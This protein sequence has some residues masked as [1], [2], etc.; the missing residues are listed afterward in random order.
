[1]NFER[2]T[3]K[4]NKK[5]NIDFTK[6]DIDVDKVCQKIYND[7]KNFDGKLI[8][9]GHSMGAY[10][11]YHFAQK[12]TSKCLFSVIID[13][14]FVTMPANVGKSKKMYENNTYSNR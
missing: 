5:P 1:M 3:M 4:H 13:G 6:D 7:V 8:L 9:L 2:S 10:F 12:Y 11:V 14:M